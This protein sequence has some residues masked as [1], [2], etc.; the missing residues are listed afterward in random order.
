LQ[1]PLPCTCNI[2]ACLDAPYLVCSYIPAHSQ[3]KI[4][5]A[6]AD[7]EMTTDISIEGDPEEIDR[8][9]KVSGSHDASLG[10]L[11]RSKVA[12]PF[13]QSPTRLMS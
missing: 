7:D 4:K 11:Q 13:F 6:T 9:R 8:F 10:C 1:S 3:V 2:G 12:V 5:M